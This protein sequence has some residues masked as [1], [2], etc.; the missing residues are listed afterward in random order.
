VG[1]CFFLYIVKISICLENENPAV[2]DAVG[3]ER[4]GGLKEPEDL[5]G[6]FIIPAMSWLAHYRRGGPLIKGS[7]DSVTAVSR[8]LSGSQPCPDRSGWFVLFQDKMN[9]EIHYNQMIWFT[10]PQCFQ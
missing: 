9:R 5:R 2:G 6:P 10:N 3:L 1:K 4:I 7:R 8:Q